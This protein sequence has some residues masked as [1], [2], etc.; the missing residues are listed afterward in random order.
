MNK[1]NQIDQ[2]NQMNQMDRRG[3]IVI[4]QLLGSLLR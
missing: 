2:T 1:T 4:A 3:I